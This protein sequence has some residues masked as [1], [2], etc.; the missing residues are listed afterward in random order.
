MRLPWAEA[1]I[2]YGLSLGLNVPWETNGQGQIIVNPPV[3]IQHAKRA[4]RLIDG[5]KAQ[6]PGWRIWPEVGI[7][8]A[9]GVKAPDLVVASPE[10]AETTDARGFLLSAPDIFIEIMSPSNSPEE[11]RHK[12]LL[13]LAAGALE[14]WICDQFGYLHFHNGTGEMAAS[15]L[16][17]EMKTYA[18]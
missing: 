16:V 7:H 8:T 18:N 17:P 4:H 5:L 15:G 10:F 12:T 9:D 2:A 1:A 11:M 3:D 13:Y 6:L 14:V